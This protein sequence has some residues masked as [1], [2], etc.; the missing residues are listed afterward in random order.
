MRGAAAAWTVT[1]P[2]ALGFDMGGTSCDTFFLAEGRRESDLTR[3][4][5]RSPGLP[6]GR[7]WSTSTRSAP[8]AARSAGSTARGSCA[9]A[10]R[11]RAPIPGRPATPRGKGADGD[12]RRPRPRPPARHSPIAADLQLD[13]DGAAVLSRR[14]IGFRRRGGRGRDR[15]RRQ[16]DGAGAAG[17]LGRAGPRTRGETLLDFGVASP[18]TRCELA[19]RAGAHAGALLPPAGCRRRWGW[20]LPSAA[21][22][23]R[24]LLELAAEAPTAR[25]EWP[26]CR[27]PPR[28][29]GARGRGPTLRAAS[30]SGSR[31]SRTA[32]RGRVRRG[33]R[34]AVRPRRRR[35]PGRAG[36]ASRSRRGARRA[37]DGRPRPATSSAATARSVGTRRGRG[38]RLHGPRAAAGHE[39][40]GPVIV[41]FPETTCLVRRAG[42]ARG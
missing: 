29:S 1:E 21:A 39:G 9:S 15:R 26:S 2:P 33:A 23:R 25:R 28:R 22:T 17:R 41:E 42:P 18:C 37:G 40:H 12:R 13:L 27:P 36:E 35:A 10:R 31:S 14:G 3:P 20:P 5:A 34:A 8:A 4:A 7:R 38:G 32:A 19:D 24:S 30:R 6:I 16:R 11:A